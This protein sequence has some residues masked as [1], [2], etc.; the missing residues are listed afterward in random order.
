MPAILCIYNDAVLNT[1]ATYDLVPQTMDERLAWFSEH[2]RAGYPVLVA[3]SDAGAVVG[4]AS[5][6]S[7]RE[8]AGY[9]Y[10]VENSVYVAA[11]A[12]GAGVGH[13]LLGALIAAGRERGYHVI[14][15]GIDAGSVA[16]LRLHAAFG[17]EEVARFREV[18]RKFDRWLDTVFL[19]LVVERATEGA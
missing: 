1:T 11:D 6:S 17:F 2:R 12:R 4:W 15:A 14:V 7:F 8:K 19:E 16:S 3:D 9:R 18:A 10:A 13:A 5:L